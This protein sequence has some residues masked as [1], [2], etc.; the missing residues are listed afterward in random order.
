MAEDSLRE[1][2]SVCGGNGVVKIP[3]GISVCPRCDGECWEPLEARAGERRDERGE[4]KA[5]V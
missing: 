3:G 2:C 1:L 4:H 5:N